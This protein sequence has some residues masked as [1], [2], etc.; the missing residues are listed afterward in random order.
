MPDSPGVGRV[1]HFRFD[2][3]DFHRT[4]TFRDADVSFRD[5]DVGFRDSDVGSRDADVGFRDA[6]VGFRD[7]AVLI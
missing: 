2:S 3:A 5:S 7:G 1:W 6:D 4:N